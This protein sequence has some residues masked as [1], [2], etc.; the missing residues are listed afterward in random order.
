[1]FVVASDPEAEMVE[2]ERAGRR[3]A[4]AA[5]A[6]VDDRREHLNPV[7]DE[8]PV[9]AVVAPPIRAEREAVAPT[10]HFGGRT[11]VGLAASDRDQR[12]SDV[13]C[14]EL[15]LS[16]RR[17]S[18]RHV[19]AAL[20]LIAHAGHGDLARQSVREPVVGAAG[21]SLG[22]AAVALATVP[23]LSVATVEHHM[24]RPDRAASDEDLGDGPRSICR[25]AALQT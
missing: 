4:C 22:L 18:L 13:A 11:L 9:A 1:V 21:P 5:L 24:R 8:L 14:G 19:D 2:H 15:V 20:A 23:R 25:H 7:A 10:A 16:R 3:P 12:P 17:R 6:F